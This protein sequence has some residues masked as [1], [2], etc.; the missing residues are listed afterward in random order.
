MYISG[1]VFF[2]YYYYIRIVR[3]LYSLTMVDD[4]V[5]IH[6]SIVTKFKCTQLYMRIRYKYL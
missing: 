2:K 4:D 1:R 5:V 3:V 6:Y